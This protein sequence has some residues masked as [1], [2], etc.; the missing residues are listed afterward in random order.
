MA[1]K[2]KAPTSPYFIFLNQRKAEI[3]EQYHITNLSEVTK[4]ASK[5]WKKLPPEEKEKYN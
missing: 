1:N 5:E 3:A 4:V 2:P